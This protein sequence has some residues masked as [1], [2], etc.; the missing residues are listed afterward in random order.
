MNKYLVVG[1]WATGIAAAQHLRSLDPSSDITIVEAEPELY[2]P[3]P[4]L[5]DYIA[6]RKSRNHLAMHDLPW[7]HDN[8]ISLTSGRRVQTIDTT[9]HRASLDDGSTISYDR[10]LLANGA[11]PFVPPLPGVRKASVFTLRTLDDA[12]RM[13]KKVSPGGN[14]VMIGGGVLGLEVARAFTERGMTATVIENTGWLL[15]RQLDQRSADMLAAH[16]Q[17]LGITA[18][19]NAESQEI[20]GQ[21]DSATGVVLKD[22]RVVRGA[23]VLFSTGVRPNVA[24][25]REAGI[26]TGR[27]VQ[28]D[29][30]LQTSAPDVYA[31]G[32]VI[33]H[34]GRLYGII[35][36]CLEQARIAAQNM[37]ASGSATY[38]GSVMSNSL[39]TC[40]VEVLSIG[41][42]N[43]TEDQHLEA[44]VAQSEQ[45]YR[46]VVLDGGV[47]VGII[48]YGTTSGSR[49]LQQAMR[50]AVDVSKFRE[51][52]SDI[53]WD[54][55]G[56]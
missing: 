37:V 17:G 14:V 3:R 20:T 13:L 7:Y 53:H 25:A 35:P 45:V 32:D 24:L 16:L 43:P 8:R 42:V 39:K 23:F 28:V 46:K 4:D 15:S 11:S 55:S 31:A 29:D 2:Y 38:K 22:G 40:G 1:G 44:I 56:M 36:P 34:H 12:D 48:L 30:F 27:G 49:Q 19:L 5:I 52:L 18:F 50:S 6:G 54:F 9:R 33:E 10:L 26:A 41:N 47:I 21:D 51:Q